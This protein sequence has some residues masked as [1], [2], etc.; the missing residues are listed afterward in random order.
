MSETAQISAAQNPAAKPSEADYSD[1]SWKSDFDALNG[2]QYILA[3]LY[4]C[5]PLDGWSSDK[6]DS[7]KIDFDIKVISNFSQHILGSLRYPF[8][9]LSPSDA[10]KLIASIAKSLPYC[11]GVCISSDIISDCKDIDPSLAS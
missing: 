5:R 6:T 4:W 8:A 9:S 2:I 11:Q 3:A 1:S 10:A 7:D